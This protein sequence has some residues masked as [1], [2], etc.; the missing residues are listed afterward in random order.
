M[1]TRWFVSFA[2]LVLLCASALTPVL[3]ED[4][5]PGWS[6]SAELSYVVTDGNSN[7]T[8]LGFKNELRRRWTK[9]LFTFKLE[10]INAENTNVTREAIGPDSMNFSVVE[11]EETEKTAEQYFAELRYNRKITERFF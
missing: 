3:A 10:G 11:T 7:T 6:D 1:S 8:T 2:C 5:E 4:D 9:A